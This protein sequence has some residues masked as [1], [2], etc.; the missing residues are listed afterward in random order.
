MGGEAQG[1]INMA[2]RKR[3]RTHGNPGRRRQTELAI[4]PYGMAM[5][6][7]EAPTRELGY[8]HEMPASVGAQV[9]SIVPAAAGGLAGLLLGFKLAGSVKMSVTEVVIASGIAA[10]SSIVGIFIVRHYH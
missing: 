10:V 2:S 9:L 3:R 4:E 6:N 8:F 1:A 5:N 7:S